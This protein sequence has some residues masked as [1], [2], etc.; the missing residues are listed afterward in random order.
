MAL[1]GP[2]ALCQPI[3]LNTTPLAGVFPPASTPG[4]DPGTGTITAWGA[5]QGVYIPN[6]GQVWL[7]W[8]AAATA[9]GVT[10]VLVGDLVGNTNAVV[11]A[12]TEQQTLAASSS[13]WLGPWSPA[14]YNQQAPTIV[15]YSGAVNTQALVAAMQGCVVIDFTTITTLAVRAYQV[16][17]VSP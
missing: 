15:T 16:I 13:G 8:A 12:T 3:P 1:P 10:Q 4:Y 17:P 14:T 9:P 7:Y 11:P 5:N 2:R 6:N